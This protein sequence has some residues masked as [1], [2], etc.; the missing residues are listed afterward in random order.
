MD[1]PAFLRQISGLESLLE[2]DSRKNL[3]DALSW[4]GDLLR[5]GVSPAEI[6][7]RIRVGDDSTLITLPG[8][9]LLTGHVGKGQQFDWAMVV[10][11]ED[12]VLPDFRSTTDEERAEEARVFSVM[13]SRARHGAIVSYSATVPT[14]AGDLKGKAPS[15]FLKYLERANPLAGDALIQWF[16]NVDW[17]Q[18]AAR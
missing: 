13:L 4:C 10:G 5:E 9:H 18:I 2:T 7:G 12:G 17:E 3:A 6:R 8:I 16:K 11:A 14:W 15:P 1:K